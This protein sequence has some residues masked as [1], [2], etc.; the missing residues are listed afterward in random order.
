MSEAPGKVDLSVFDYQPLDRHNELIPQLLALMSLQPWP[1]HTSSSR[2]VMYTGHLGQAL[3]IKGATPRRCQTGTEREFGKYTFNLKLP[4]TASI[5]RIIPKYS[6]T[7]YGQEKIKQ[8]PMSILVYENVE[9]KEVGIVNLI[10]HS[11]AI[12]S[13]HQH[14]GF[15]YKYRS[16]VEAQ[17]T[18]GNI[19]PE[20]TV[21]ADSPAVDRQGNY[22]FG[23]ETPVALMSIPGII[24]DGVVVSRS[25]LD[26]ITS[27]GH[28]KRVASWGKEYYPL[29]LYGDQDNYKPFP[30]IGDRIRDDGLL[31]ALRRYDELLAPIEMRPDRL[32]E[33]DYIFDKL[34]YGIPNA[35]VT[36]VMV[37]H[38]QT[39]RFSPTPVGMEGQCEKYL[40]GTDQFYESLVDVYK[41]LRR[42]KG[43]A[44]R[45]TPE[46]QRLL[47]EALADQADP[48]K[49]RVNKMYRRNPLDDYRVEIAFEYDVVPTVGFKL[50][51]CHGDKGVICG[52]WEDEDMPVDED[53]N[54]A[55]LI[56]D[57]DSTIKR[58]NLGRLYEQYLNAASRD[59]SKRVRAMFGLNRNGGHSEIEIQ[60]AVDSASPEV[61]EEAWTYLMG[62]YTIT[63]PRMV[64]ALESEAYAKRSTKEDHLKAICDDGVYLNIPTDNPPESTEMIRLIREHYPPTF[65]PVTYS[66]GV[67]THNPIL[68]GSMYIMLLEKTGVDWSGVAS[69]KLQ[70]FGIPARV[71]N[72]DKY[73]APGRGQP[74]RM[75]GEAEVRLFNATVGSRIT[76]DLLDQSNSPGTHKEIVKNILTAEHPTNIGV[77][78]DRDKVPLGN[79][80][81]LVFVNH[82]M[83]CAGMRFVREDDPEAG[84]Y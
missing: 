47:V 39:Q 7:Q 17:L 37:H 1:G 73:A 22:C 8:N 44:L 4:C 46:L 27:V 19:L 9:T 77:V 57:A 15:R 41:E 52:V 36:D 51:G 10:R 50:T 34:F 28:E 55:E 45:I 60:Q 26:R 11:T 3:Q 21:I 40:R 24:E 59:V 84:E 29:N 33:P 80:R 6:Q 68:I 69:A 74:V 76:A 75:L 54:R 20:G 18:R 61:R 32:E 71:T 43:E 66:G 67:K 30:D 72:M 5:I 42:N 48:G 12:D 35:K 31:F 81:A 58:M 49:Q 70:H 56:M 63:S 16:E 14:F 25:Y 38:D 79:S 13:M 62:Y 2:G 78:V 65:G 83:E 53:G 64:T 23:V 82:I